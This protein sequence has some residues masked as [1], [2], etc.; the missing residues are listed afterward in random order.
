MKINMKKFAKPAVLVTAAIATLFLV[1]A[2]ATSGKSDVQKYRE[3]R[4]Y[5]EQL[6]QLKNEGVQK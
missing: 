2:F 1:D 6:E 3:L 4:A 5:H